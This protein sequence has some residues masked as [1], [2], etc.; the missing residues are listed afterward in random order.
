MEGRSRVVEL[1]SRS[2]ARPSSVVELAAKH[3]AFASRS[4]ARPSTG[5]ERA[6]DAAALGAARRAFVSG[7]EARRERAL[8][9]SAMASSC[10]ANLRTP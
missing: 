7:E 1:A 10:G 2:M 3:V 6:A 8:A 5:V 4:M 9:A